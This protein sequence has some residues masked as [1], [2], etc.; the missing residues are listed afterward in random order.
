M[1]KAPDITRKPWK[2]VLSKRY[3]FVVMLWLDGVVADIVATAYTPSDDIL[4]LCRLFTDEIMFYFGHAK[5]EGE[6]YN[7]IEA[8]FEEGWLDISVE[9]A[10]SFIS[11]EEWPSVSDWE[12]EQAFAKTRIQWLYGDEPDYW[13][14]EVWKYVRDNQQLADELGWKTHEEVFDKVYDGIADA[15]DQNKQALLYEIGAITRSVVD[16]TGFDAR[17]L[18]CGM[19]SKLIPKALISWAGTAAG[20]LAAP[21]KKALPWRKA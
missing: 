9:D 12:M 14:E 16:Q 10:D 4:E 5:T 21:K 3:Q 13:P 15:I 6:L 2:W 11:T 17:K 20:R 18:I 7:F 19:A 1:P 8:A